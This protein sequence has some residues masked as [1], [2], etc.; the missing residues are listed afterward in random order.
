MDQVDIVV[1][2]VDEM[3]LVVVALY[4]VDLGTRSLDEEDKLAQPGTR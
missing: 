3:E 1:L 2:A 4:K